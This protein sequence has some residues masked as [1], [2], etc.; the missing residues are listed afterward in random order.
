MAKDSLVVRAIKTFK[1]ETAT[2]E[3]GEVYLIWGPNAQ[4]RIRVARERIKEGL[5]EEVDPDALEDED[6]DGDADE[7]TAGPSWSDHELGSFQFEDNGYLCWTIKLPLPAFDAYNLGKKKP[8]KDKRPLYPLEI[9]VDSE[10]DR[11]D[12]PAIALAKQIIANQ[13]TLADKVAEALW[14]DFT[15]TGP[16][17]GMYWHGELDQVAEGLESGEPPGGVEDLYKLM[18]LARVTVRQAGAPG[19]YVAELNFDAKFEEDHGVGILTDGDSV[20]GIG[21]SG[22]AE[23]FGS[24]G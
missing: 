16:E 24:R 9:V 19:T 6:E 11:P 23:P 22:E 14:A 3:A 1:T 20:T 15:G 13:A 5:F 21:H 18:K 4:E 8:R 17:S 12:A 2:Y 10:N 7:T